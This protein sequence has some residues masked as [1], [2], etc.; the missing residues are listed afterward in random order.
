VVNLAPSKL[1]E[2]LA[3]IALT[4]AIII[5]LLNQ[6]SGDNV[7]FIELL[8][9][10]TLSAYRIMPSM[11][12]LNTNFMG[13][14]G[15]I[16]I[17]NSAEKGEEYYRI[18]QPENSPVLSTEFNLI[19]VELQS[20]ELGY[21][22]LERSVINNLSSTLSSG[23]LHAIVGPSGCGKST[24]INAILGIHKPVNGQVKLTDSKTK[25]ELKKDSWLSCTAYLSQQPFLFSGSIRDN[26]T[27]R[28][29]GIK[30]DEEKVHDLI[31]RLELDRCLGPNPL[32]FQL[33]EGGMNLSG[34]EQQRLALLRAI[35][36]N[37]PVLIIDEATSAL[38][39]RMSAKIIEILKEMASEGVNIIMVTHDNELAEKCDDI[40]ELTQL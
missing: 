40:L 16:H 35:Q 21:E 33:N 7:G 6:Q 3:I 22:S 39:A 31:M 15:Q 12:R 2:V 17:L 25:E 4:G 1:Y 18:S 13:M 23:K 20:L 28:V 30:L 24:L 32:D 26:L 27:L 36:I 11:S 38:D 34:G 37:R 10:L 14:Q 29:P 8:T 5:S 19:D 9:I